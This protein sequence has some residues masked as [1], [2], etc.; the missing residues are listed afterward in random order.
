MPIDLEDGLYAHPLVRY[1]AAVPLDHDPIT[2]SA[3][4]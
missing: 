3:S 1:A 4:S 2:C